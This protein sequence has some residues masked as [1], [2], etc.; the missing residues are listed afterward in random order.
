[1]AHVTATPETT[2]V[3]RPDTDE[4]VLPEPPWVTIVWDDPVNLMSYVAFV[5]AD[6]FRYS[7]AKAKRRRTAE[8]ARRNRESLTHRSGVPGRLPGDSSRRSRIGIPA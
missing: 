5:F 7:K 1:M 4:V 8:P 3:E 6:Y 2:T